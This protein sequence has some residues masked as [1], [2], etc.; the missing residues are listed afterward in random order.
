MQSQKQQNDFCHFHGKPFNITVIQIYAPI[1]NIEETEL[2]Q[3]Y[4]DLQDLLELAPSKRCLF[5]YRGLECISRKSRNPW[6]NRQIWPWSTEW[7]RAKASRVLPRERIGHHIQVIL[8]KFNDRL[9]K[10][11]RQWSDIFKVLKEK[12][13]QSRIPHTAKVFPKPKE[14]LRKP[15]VKSSL[16][17]L[18]VGVCYDQCIF[19]AKLY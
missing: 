6:S 14:K 3:F 10:K 16:V 5:H 11:P 9:S 2:E 7:S 4:E 13:C 12:D 19:L 8:N 1:S 17:V 18:E 15:C